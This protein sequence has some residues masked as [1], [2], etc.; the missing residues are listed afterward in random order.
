M[1]THSV[2]HRVQ[3]RERVTSCRTPEATAIVNNIRLSAEEIESMRSQQWDRIE[4]EVRGLIVAGLP[5]LP[6]CQPGCVPGW[7]FLNPTQKNDILKRCR[8]L[9]KVAE[10]ARVMR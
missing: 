6:P 10:R 2:Q 9:E 5:S 7:S 3:E 8:L 4:Q 1:I